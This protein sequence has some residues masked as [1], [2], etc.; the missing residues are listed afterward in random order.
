MLREM[1]DTGKITR[2]VYRKFYRKSKGGLFR[3]KRQLMLHL[4]TEGHLKEGN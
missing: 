3:S 4:K 1:R 2:S